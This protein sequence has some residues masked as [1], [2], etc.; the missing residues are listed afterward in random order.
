MSEGMAG[1]PLT[2]G[3]CASLLS[4]RQTDFCAKIQRFA[5]GEETKTQVPKR[6]KVYS[7]SAELPKSPKL[8]SGDG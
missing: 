3:N 8:L 1:C 5:I 4:A 7:C 2:G 6:E